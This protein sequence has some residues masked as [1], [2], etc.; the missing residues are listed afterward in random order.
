MAKIKKDSISVIIPALNEE[1]H[2]GNTISVVLGAVKDI[3]DNY[4]IIIFNDGSTDRTGEIADML[5]EKYNYVKVIH[6]K[7]PICI[8]G[9]YKR[10]IKLA[11]M[12]YL[13]RINGKDDITKENLGKIFSLRRR[14]DIIIPYTVN[15]NE[16]PLSRR[17]ISKVFTLLLNTLFRL[18]LQYYNHYV[19]YKRA[20][21]SSI[22]LRTNSYAF[23]AEILIK[24]IRSGFSYVEV[25]VEDKF[26]NDVKTK[27]FYHHNI[28]GVILFLFKMI[29][30]IYIK[31]NTQK[32]E[33]L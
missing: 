10:G 17:I 22:N 16:R 32:Y 6:Y 23:Q 20:V 18:N 26:E 2:L 31:K 19:L 12:D 28:F 5:A 11:K 13:I 25:A 4:E 14:A 27:A 30:E 24:L 21:V 29:E 9:I 3:F 8:G 15:S 1:K 33:V 7:K